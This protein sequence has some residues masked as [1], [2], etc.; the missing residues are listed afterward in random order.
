[1]EV[2]NI[3]FSSGYI[4]DFT[5]SGVT[6]P[7]G[8]EDD[9]HWSVDPIPPSAPED[10]DGN[11]VQFT[12]YGLPS[13][14][15]I[16]GPKNLTASLPE[17]DEISE[18]TFYPFQVFYEKDDLYP[19]GQHNET[20]W[21]IFWSNGDVVE[22]RLR[23]FNF[24]PFYTAE[25]GGSYN[26]ISDILTITR[27]GAERFPGVTLHEGLTFSA[28]SGIDLAK[29]VVL[30][31]YYHKWIADQWRSPSGPW[32]LQYGAHPMFNPGTHNTHDNDGD[33][34]PN[35]YE[36][37]ISDTYH[38]TL[39]LDPNSSATYDMSQLGYGSELKYEWDQ[40]LVAYLVSNG[41]IGDHPELDWSH[42]TYS[43]NWP[44]H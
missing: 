10:R 29:Q 35:D 33:G 15:S 36:S 41:A 32:F 39:R 5:C 6:N 14:N 42:G 20:N 2:D 3:C 16:F 40:E 21:F 19:G 22:P 17:F 4:L 23:N 25:E 37:Q 9:L 1:M 43:K 27:N 34:L 18:P 26:P 28:C 7:T 38:L 24:D 13:S 30:H 31:E 12:F 11:R 44:T 8:F